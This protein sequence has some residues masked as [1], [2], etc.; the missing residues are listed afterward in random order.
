MNNLID[1]NC[2]K[3]KDVLESIEFNETVQYVGYIKIDVQ[4][5]DLDIVKSGGEILKNKVVYITL[6]AETTYSS[7][8]NNSSYTINNYMSSIGFIPVKLNNVIDPTY[9]NSNFKHLYPPEKHGI[10]CIQNN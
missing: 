4:G 9:L 10:L 8:Q 5:A 2:C 1:V 7:G 3:L 6:E